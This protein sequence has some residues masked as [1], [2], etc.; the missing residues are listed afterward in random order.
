MY[1]FPHLLQT[2]QS[3]NH[4]QFLSDATATGNN[5]FTVP[6]GS[7]SSGALSVKFTAD[8]VRADSRTVIQGS[9]TAS[10][11]YAQPV[12]TSG[13]YNKVTYKFTSKVFNTAGTYSYL[14]STANSSGAVQKTATLTITVS[15]AN[16][17]PVLANSSIYITGT[18][19]P[20]NAS[21]GDSALVVTASTI[22]ATRTASGFITWLQRNADSA[23]VTTGTSAKTVGE[24][25]TAI[26]TGSAGQVS[27]GG[28]AA[29]TTVGGVSAVAAN[30][31][32]IVVWSDGRVGTA[33]ITL[34]TPSMGTFATKTMTFYGSTVATLTVTRSPTT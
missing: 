8:V 16:T 34:S 6:V 3:F 10:T 18:N 31:E 14:I 25:V 26:I 30:Y 33:T 23:T 15:A 11:M 1:L 21:N 9:D 7:D 19:V 32:S 5:Y 22:A 24:S 27:V 2:H 17:T 13:T 28:A 29:S 20:F 4:Q 12:A